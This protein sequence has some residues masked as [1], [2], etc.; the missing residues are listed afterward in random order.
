[1]SWSRKE[2]L[3]PGI[4][5]PECKGVPCCVLETSQV[6]NFAVIPWVFPHLW[7]RCGL[8]S[9]LRPAWSQL[10]GLPNTYQLPIRNNRIL[11]AA[12]DRLWKKMPPLVLVLASGNPG[13]TCQ[14]SVPRT[15]HGL[16]CTLSP[17]SW[18]HVPLWVLFLPGV[19]LALWFHDGCI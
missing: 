4:L 8:G 2:Q 18:C 19:V 6:C 11:L 17:E 12:G 7:E 14:C 9:T 5:T 13:G 15:E 10:L 3:F 16:Y 1:M